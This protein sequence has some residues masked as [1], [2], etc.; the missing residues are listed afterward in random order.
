VRVRGQ[1]GQVREQALLACRVGELVDTGRRGADG[2]P[3]FRAIRR[4]LIVQ[5]LRFPV[6]RYVVRPSPHCAITLYVTSLGETS[7]FLL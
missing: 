6:N 2:Q 1:D 3:I 4:L 5:A 7:I